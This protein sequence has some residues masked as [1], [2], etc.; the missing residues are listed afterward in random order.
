[1]SQSRVSAGDFNH[2]PARVRRLAREADVIIETRGEPTEVVMSYER[3]KQLIGGRGTP[4]DYIADEAAADIEFDIPAFP[5]P[6][7]PASL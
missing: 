4:M 7:T 2:Y 6:A 1:M 5:D 3:Y